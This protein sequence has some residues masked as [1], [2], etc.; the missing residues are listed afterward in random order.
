M[1]LTTNTTYSLELDDKERVTL[2]SI[3]DRVKQRDQD[4]QNKE[5]L[6]FIE[7]AIS[8]LVVR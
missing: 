7:R 4:L 1:N 6:D 5:M 2:M 8:C 3:L